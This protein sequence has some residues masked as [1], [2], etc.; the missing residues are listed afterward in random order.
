MKTSEVEELLWRVSWISKTCGFMNH[1]YYINVHTKF[2]AS[3]MPGSTLKV[4][5]G[6]GGWWFKATLVFC[7]GPKLECCPCTRNWS[8]LNNKVSIQSPI[9]CISKQKLASLTVFVS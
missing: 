4:F 1:L 7:V 9:S 8:K 5:G 3:I 6:G 2:L